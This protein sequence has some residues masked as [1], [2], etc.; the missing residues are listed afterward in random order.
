MSHPDEGTIQALLDDELSAAER[1]EVLTHVETCPACA[2]RVAEARGYQQEADRLVG[3]IE[4]PELLTI[5]PRRRRP[6]VV[7]TL[8]W[9]ASIVLAVALGYWGRGP[10]RPAPSTVGEGTVATGISDA[11]P[12]SA[13]PLPAVQEA[14]KSDVPSGGARQ[15][16]KAP[17]IEPAPT[18]PTPAPAGK[19]IGADERRAAANE[20]EAPAAAPASLAARDAAAS[21]ALAWRVVTMEEAVTQLGGQIR[22]IDGLAPERVELGPGTAVAGADA[23]RPVVRVV[24][25][26]GNVVLDQQRPAMDLARAEATAARAAKTAQAQAGASTL[27]GRVTAWQVRDGIRFVVTGSVAPDSLAVLAARVR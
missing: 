13:A 26:G 21:P 16:A 20:A 19:E 5:P 2:A 22:L 25:A 15:E 9:A 24:Y 12:A 18:A 6:S 14:P 4:V 3:V 27:E 23:G 8:A 17:T 1:V 11:P 10:V 7:R